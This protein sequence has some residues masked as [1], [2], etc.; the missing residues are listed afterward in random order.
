MTTRLGIYLDGGARGAHLWLRMD[1]TNGEIIDRGETLDLK[2]LCLPSALEPCDILLRGDLVG[3]RKVTMPEMSSATALTAAPAMI[4]EDVAVD[5][6]ALHCVAMPA[7]A[8]GKRLL[9]WIDRAQV[10]AVLAD[11]HA[12]GLRP[13]RMAADYCGLAVVEGQARYAALGDLILVAGIDVAP[14][15]V[16]ANLMPRIAGSVG[17]A[18]VAWQDLPA[19]DAS[20]L[21]AGYMRNDSTHVLNLMQGHYRPRYAMAG[22]ASAWWRVALAAGLAAAA[23]TAWC[24]ADGIAANRERD[25][26]LLQMDQTY[27]EL[28]PGQRIVN[29]P[30]Q[31]RN[32]LQAHRAAGSNFDYFALAARVY[33]ATREVAGVGIDTLRFDAVNGSLKLTVAAADFGQLESLRGRLTS[34]QFDVSDSGARET[35]SGVAG[36]WELRVR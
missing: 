1:E 26:A 2:A 8:T 18:D 31:M 24:I 21:L 29:A 6:D 28:F 11:L 27:R 7:D 33:T 22:N 3:C 10:D 32:A 4:E 25:V 20:D 5:V 16:Q 12:A 14:F 9:G 36:E 23:A 15:A 34:Q 35:A 30:V 19:I 17:L 13:E